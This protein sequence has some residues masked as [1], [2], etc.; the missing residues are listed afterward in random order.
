MNCL[1]C[2]KPLALQP[3]R[4]RKYCSKHCSNLHSY[5][6]HTARIAMNHKHPDKTINEVREMAE[7]AR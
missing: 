7:E 5:A 3:P 1:Q 6:T 2:G 4:K